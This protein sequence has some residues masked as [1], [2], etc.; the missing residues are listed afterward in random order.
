MKYEQRGKPLRYPQFDLLPPLGDVIRIRVAYQIPVG[1]S[2][3][4]APEQANSY[5]SYEPKLS[6]RP[7]ESCH[8]QAVHLF[9]ALVQTVVLVAG[10][11]LQQQ[12]QLM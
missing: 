4:V 5:P 11:H 9:T 7:Q 2:L 12:G 1:T 6:W 8:L 10:R 3:H